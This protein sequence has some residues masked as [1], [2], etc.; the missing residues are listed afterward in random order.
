MAEEKPADERTEAATPR[1]REKARKD[2]DLFQSRE[3]AT[4]M[5]GVAGAL[6]LMLFSTDLSDAL[7]ATATQAFAL[8]R[9]DIVAFQPVSAM[10]A[11]LAPLF[12]PLL[13][14]AALVTTAVVGGQA[15][16]GS[17]TVN[18]ALLAPKGSRINPLAGLKRLFGPKG[19]IELL[20]ALLKAGLMLGLSAWLLWQDAPIL[21][22]LSAMPLNAALGALSD[23]GL[24]LFLW[25]S[26]GLAVIAGGDVPVQFLQW[27]KRLRMSL[28]DVKDEAKEQ[29]G[30]P[31]MK[32]AMRRMARE[33][34]KRSNR[35]AMAEATVVL[36]NPTHFA[37]ALRYR[38]GKD[39]APVIVA[40][41]RGIVAEA[42]RELAADQ[43]VMILSYPSVARALYFTGKVG[44]GIRID[45]YAAVAT[46]LAFVLRAHADAADPPAAEAPES[47]LFDEGGRRANAS[48]PR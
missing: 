2:G 24:S 46:I 20:K 17:L 6:W 5:V 8:A 32:W 27:L 41:G 14:L 10:Q 45:L 29:E 47:A 22:R 30:S 3:L 38:P 39:A 25:L 40:R 33:S 36:T 48:S 18:I 12:P 13:A 1:R 16:T 42:I 9:A 35:T 37:V 43:G 28:Q 7:R 26:L 34:L 23:M 44:S 31:D 15:L 21:L 4:A 19:L 11:M